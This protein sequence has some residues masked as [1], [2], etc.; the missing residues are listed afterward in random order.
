MEFALGGHQ[1]QK[2]NLNFTQVQNPIMVSI[3]SVLE[4]LHTHY[5]VPLHKILH[6]AQKQSSQKSELC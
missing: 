5:P 4:R 1:N 6:T 3:S 2:W